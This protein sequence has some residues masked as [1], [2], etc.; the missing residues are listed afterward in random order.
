[1]A[2]DV[3]RVSNRLEDAKGEMSLDLSGCKL[4]AI[5]VAMFMVLKK[6]LQSILVVNLAD[7]ELKKVSPKLSKFMNMQELYLMGNVISNWGFVPSLPFS[8]QVLSLDRCGLS[9]LP[10]ELYGC[11]QLRVLSVQ[12][13]E[14]EQVDTEKIRNLSN[15]EEL[16]VRGNNIPTAIVLTLQQRPFSLIL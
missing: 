15:L 13:N 6:E 9:S 2:N 8:L 12:D 1:M 3:A 4:T 16:D 7:N 5:P 10:A 14:L 11:A